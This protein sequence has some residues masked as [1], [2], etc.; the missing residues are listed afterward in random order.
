MIGS[1]GEQAQ[2]LQNALPNGS[3]FV[4]RE[5]AQLPKIMKQV[6]SAIVDTK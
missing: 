3:G 4:C 6:F 1:L 5:T 2:R